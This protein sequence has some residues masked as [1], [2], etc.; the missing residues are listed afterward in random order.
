MN[1][2]TLAGEVLEG[3]PLSILDGGDALGTLAQVVLI[4]LFSWRVAEEGD[5][6]P[7][8]GVRNGWWA[9]AFADDG[10]RFGSRLW[11]LGR[12]R[13]DLAAVNAARGYAIEAL[14]WIVT[15]GLAA[16]VDVT[17]ERVGRDAIG[18]GVTV[19]RDDGTGVVL[20]FDD[21]WGAMQ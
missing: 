18:L 17:A 16:R 1:A 3:D 15:D 21:F 20:R 19:Q 5:A 14:A 6:L 12:A 4:S 9:D 10:D 2:Y 13:P 11:L 8:A 7:V